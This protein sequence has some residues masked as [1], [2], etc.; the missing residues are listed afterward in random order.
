MNFAIGP[1]VQKY[2]LNCLMKDKF[3]YKGE[4]DKTSETVIWGLVTILKKLGYI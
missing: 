3:K 1:L 4:G 2:S